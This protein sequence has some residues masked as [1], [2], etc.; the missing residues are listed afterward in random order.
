[1]NDRWLKDIVLDT[2]A[3][4]TIVRGDLVTEEDMVGSSII[5]KC[6]HG[7]EVAYPA[8]QVKIVVEGVMY[9]LEVAVSDSLPV[10]V[11]LGRDVP[12]LVNIGKTKRKFSCVG[13]R[14]VMAVT[15]RAQAGEACRGVSAG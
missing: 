7:D 3:A 15:T 1:M 6:A 2:G 4:K 11:L 5:V 10:S 8:A 13:V 14:D 12:D 9:T